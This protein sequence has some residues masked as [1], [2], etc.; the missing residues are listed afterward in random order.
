MEEEE[1]EME[2]G[3]LYG[4][5]GDELW[6]EECGRL[7]V[8]ENPQKKKMMVED[9]VVGSQHQQKMIKNRESAARSRERKQV[10]SLSL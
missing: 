6:E 4:G 1:E 5:M 10:L 7:M 3:V 8:A 9:V 2:I